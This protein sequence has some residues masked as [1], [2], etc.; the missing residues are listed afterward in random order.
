[1]HMATIGIFSLM[2]ILTA[3]ADDNPALEPGSAVREFKGGD[4]DRSY[5]ATKSGDHAKENFQAEITVTIPNGKGGTGIAFFGLGKGQAKADD[6]NQPHISPSLSFRLC[7]D[8]FCDGQVAAFINGTDTEE[9]AKLG[10]GTHRLR[11]TWDAERKCAWFEAHRNWKPDAKFAPE[12]LLFVP[13][14]NVDFA[15]E[16]RLF[17][18]GAGGVTFTDFS[19]K[20]DIKIDLQTPPKGDVFKN[21]PSART[22]LPTTS[23][24]KADKSV[25]VD[26]LKPLRGEIRPLVCWYKGAQLQA[27]RSIASGKLELPASKWSCVIK[28]DRSDKSDWSDLTATFTLTEGFA[29][30]AGVALAFDFTEWSRDNYVLVPAVVYNGNRFHALGGNYMPAYPKE[31]YF[32]P[33]LPLTMSNNPRLSVEP[34]KASK[35]ELL[36]GNAATPAICF[37][38]PKLKRGFILLCEQKTKFGNNGLFIEENAAQDKITFVV[39]APGVRETAA[40]FGGF[41]ASGDKAA[42]WKVGDELKLKFR[43]YSFPADGISALL[44][45]FMSVRKA[46]TGPNQP[47]NLVPMSKMADTI[48]PRFKG[49]WMTVKAGNYY[50]MENSPHFQIGWVSGFMQTPLLAIDDPVERERMGKQFD[51]VIGKLQGK[52][53][54]F[55]GGIT[56]EGQLRADRQLDSRIFAL[57]RKNAD[58]LLMFFKFFQILKAQGHSDFIRPE[59][60]QSAKRLA[61]AYVDTWKKYGE[62]GQYVDPETGEIAVYNSTSAAIAPGGLVLASQY[63]NEPEF[64][65]VAKES[66]KFYYERDVAGLGMTAGHSG[67]TSQDPDADSAYGF[68]ESL[69]ALYWATGDN[70]WLDKAKVV[71]DLGASWTLSYDEEFPPQSQIA[72]IGGHMAGAIW[73][74]AQNK[75]AAPGICTASGDYI[76]KLYRATGEEQY[77]EL[78]RDIQHAHVEATDMPGHPTCGAGT[79]ASM[80]RIQPTDGEGKGSIGNFVY[81]Q[82]AWTELDGLMMVMELP[83]IYLQTDADKFYVFDSVEAKVI[84]RDANGVKIEITNPTEYDAKV[85]IFAETAEQAKKPMGYTEYLKWPKVEVKVGETKTFEITP[86]GSIK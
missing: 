75:H 6:Y 42:D 74:S 34:D 44:E 52:S 67:D 36:T 22:W 18:G 63:F 11:M 86:N 3:V 77:A 66:A 83:G 41:T 25:L 38:S 69:M 35:I 64:L 5:A 10:S 80:E 50:A 33:K 68:V 28:S 60:E 85:S 19:V 82:N 53:G 55:Y 9:H 78:I 1:M 81:T 46:F 57:T 51:F 16:G 54:Y 39:S 14:I 12:L 56:A 24:D 15:K 43:V 58:T 23:S 76:F 59:W 70:E 4:S 49:R 17:A 79:G 32:D 26:L 20:T 29:K 7:P 13:D 31:M 65:R 40:G 48:I 45:K 27:S 47:R 37:Y 2:F 72:K 71:A 73:A 8:D 30:E 62:F 21:D 84:S 61:Q